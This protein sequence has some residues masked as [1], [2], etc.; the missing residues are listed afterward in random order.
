MSGVPWWMMAETP[1]PATDAAT[2]AAPPLG[3]ARVR[4]YVAALG[5]KHLV[6]GH[7]PGKIDFGDSVTRA[8][9]EPFAYEGV[10]FLIDTGMS[11]GQADGRG[12]VL[13][14]PAGT[15]ER[16]TV[17]DETGKE[18]TLWTAQRNP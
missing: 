10:L 13:H 2:S 5:C 11:R 8:A 6:V 18:T 9:G 4:Q 14:L 16:A 12:I 1:A 15:V 7:Q 3:F 17:I